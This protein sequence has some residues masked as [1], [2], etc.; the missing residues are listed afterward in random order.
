MRSHSRDTICPS[1]C[2]FV[3]PLLNR[4]RREG[5]APAAPASTVCNGRKK[6]TRLHEYSQDIPAFP[7]QWLYGLYVLSPV[8]GVVCHR[9]KVGLTTR[10]TP[11]SRRQDHTIS[12]YAAAF[13]PARLLA[14][15]PQAS[16]A[17]RATFRDDREAP[18]MA[19]RADWLLPQIR[20]PVKRIIFDRGA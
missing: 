19:A 13:S 17:T 4:G 3:G 18:L 6:R 12:P 10:L 1:F 20:I 2:K 15:T 7:A 11:R 14:L 8:S 5:R 9:R 16:I